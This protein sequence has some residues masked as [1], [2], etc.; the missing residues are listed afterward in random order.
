MK[1]MKELCVCWIFGKLA[2]VFFRLLKSTGRLKVYGYSVDKFYLKNKNMVLISN[3]PSFLETILL[4]FLFAP[5]HNFSFKLPCSLAEKKYYGAWWFP[6]RPVCMPIER[7]NKRDELKVLKEIKSDFLKNTEKS[8]ILYPEGARTAKGILKRGYR[9]SE[10]G[11]TIAVF[12]KGIE[13]LFVDSDF[14]VLPVWTEG[15]SEIMSGKFWRKIKIVIGEPFKLSAQ[16]GRIN[17]YLESVLLE[18]AD[19]Y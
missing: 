6:W 17:D 7:G 16:K 11:K 12:P 1:K 18:L 3:H 5:N 14:Y 9:R 10:N 2:G 8:L 15:G 19:R 4:P 13:R